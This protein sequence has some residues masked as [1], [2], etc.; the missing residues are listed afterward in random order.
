[1]TDERPYG[2]HFASRNE[3]DRIEDPHGP[4]AASAAVEPDEQVKETDQHECESSCVSS[5]C[6]ES[7][8]DVDCQAEPAEHA[9][10][11]STREALNPRVS[12]SLASPFLWCCSSSL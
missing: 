4:E 12:A 7:S 6:E 9:P 8:E 1:M 2:R 5:E 3:D 10:K 11:I